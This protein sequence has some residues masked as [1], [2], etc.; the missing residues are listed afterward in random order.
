[1]LTL[2]S[3][4]AATDGGVWGDP[5][6]LDAR[7][8]EIGRILPLRPQQWACLLRRAGRRLVAGRRRGEEDGVLAAH[9]AVDAAEGGEAS[10]QQL[11]VAL[12]PGGG[13]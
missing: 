3:R 4:R 10:Q 12:R 7:L 5:P 8:E 13:A 6:T 2:L 1:M 11:L 9:D